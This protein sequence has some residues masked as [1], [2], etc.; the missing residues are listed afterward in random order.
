MLV[1]TFLGISH[2][3][4]IIFLLV[5]FIEL[6]VFISQVYLPALDKRMRNDT[7]S[8]IEYITFAN[9]NICILT[10]LN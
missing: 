2:L 10:R 4:N 9:Y 8:H 3:F 5:A 7:A 1:S 6:L